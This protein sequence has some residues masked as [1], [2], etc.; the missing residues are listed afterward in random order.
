MRGATGVSR[1]RAL[2]V[3]ECVLGRMPETLKA[4]LL[5]AAGVVLGLLPSLLSFLASDI[6]EVGLRRPELALLLAA[7]SP[8]VNPIKVCEYSDPLRL[9]LPGPETDAFKVVGRYFGATVVCRFLAKYEVRGMR[10]VLK[11]PAG[12]R[13]A[14]KAT[15]TDA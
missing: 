2:P 10:Q 11:P 14:D 7:G 5:A 8:A 13:V 4:N 3:V 12:A 15:M 6:T 9:L 1:R